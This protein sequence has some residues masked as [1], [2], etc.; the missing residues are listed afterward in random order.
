MAPCLIGVDGGTESLRAGVF[1]LRG[2][3]LAFAAAPYATRFPHPGWAEQDPADWWAALGRAVRRAVAEA[4]V[5]PADVSAMA[6]DTT[7]CSVVALDAAGRALRPALIWMDVRAAA[8]ACAVLESG[9]PA[10]RVNGDGHGP[11]SAEWLL[12]KALWLRRH[13]PEAFAAAAHVCEYQDYLNHRLTGRMCASIANA[14]VRWHYLPRQGGYQ[15]RL[16]AALGLGELAGKLPREVLPLGATV[17]GLT[18]AAADHL[19]LPAGLPVA[20]GGS[21]AFVGIIGLGVI[22]A[23][24]MAMVTGS[25]HLQ[26][27]LAERPFHGR[28]IWGTYADAVIPGLHVVEGGQTSTGS[29]IRWLRGLFGTAA[30]YAAL[31]AEAAAVP[32][33]SEGLLALEHFQGS[34][35]PHTDPASRGAFVGLALKHGRGHLFRA[36][37]EAIACGTELALETMRAHGYAPADLTVAGGATRSDLWLQIHADVSGLPLRLTRVPDAPALGCAVLAAVAAGHYDGIAAA[38]GE[39]VQVVRTV[40]PDPAATAAYGPVYDAYK[41]LYPALAPLHHRLAGEG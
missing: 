9:D 26:L 29:V 14:A 35:T 8:E 24:R 28:G 3:P 23:P 20:Q 30:D 33:G 18:A 25:S 11:V 5:R 10:L 4:G 17:G 32:P 7:C 38:A 16:L 34:R 12:P 21:D 1:D 41:A 19:G 13:E 6:V 2:R 27:G 15:P 37:I 36:A 40:E 39:M 31:N 22:T